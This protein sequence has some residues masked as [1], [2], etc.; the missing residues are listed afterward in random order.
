MAIGEHDELH[1]A[2]DLASKQEEDR[3]DSDDPQEERT[4]KAL[5]IGNKAAGAKS[6]R[7][8]QQ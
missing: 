6:Q 2:N 3:N 8:A 1:K 4:E 7:D 5:Q